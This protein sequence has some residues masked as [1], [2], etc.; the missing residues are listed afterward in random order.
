MRQKFLKTI[1]RKSHNNKIIDFPIFEI[2][3]DSS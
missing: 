1:Y 3:D 2:P